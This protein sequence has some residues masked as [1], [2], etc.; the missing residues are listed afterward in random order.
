MTR[1]WTPVRPLAAVNRRIARHFAWRIGCAKLPSRHPPRCAVIGQSYRAVELERFGPGE[2][3]CQ[4]D[5]SFGIALGDVIRPGR[6]KEGDA[7][8]RAAN[9]LTA[10]FDAKRE[11]YGSSPGRE[12]LARQVKR[13]DLLLHDVVARASRPDVSERGR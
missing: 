5:D 4:R 2:V 1:C 7:R 9:V 3:A 6:G 13:A 10:M 11:R 12:W 8:D